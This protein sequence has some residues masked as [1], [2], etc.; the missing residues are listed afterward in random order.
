M[1]KG[2][3]K[4]KYNSKGLVVKSPIKIENGRKFYPGTIYTN[5][6][7]EKYVVLDYKDPFNVTIQFLDKHGYTYTTYRSSIVA[8]NVKNPYRLLS[9]GNYIGDGP[10]ARKKDAKAYACWKNINTRVF[11]SNTRLNASLEC[12]E[13]VQICEE[14]KNFQNFA[15]WYYDQLANLNSKY[16]YSIDKDI[17]Q[18][19]SNI[20]IYSPETAAMVPTNLNL[21]LSSYKNIVSKKG[22]PT[23]VVRKAN[24]YYANL[25]NSNSIDINI[26]LEYNHSGFNTPEEAFEE[27]RTAKISYIRK[28]AD[29]YYSENAISKTIRDALC[30]IDIIPF[31]DNQLRIQ[32]KSKELELQ[33]K[34][35]TQLE[36][37]V[38]YYKDENSKLKLVIYDHE[39]EIKKLQEQI[40]SSITIKR[41]D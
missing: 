8:G 40:R 39:A 27:Y 41:G 37:E 11:E 25:Y 19:N 18:W 1:P 29:F 23:G 16:K 15:Q 28:I 17:L 6:E 38:E 10:Y 33:R 24:L 22:L 31:S 30:D 32:D 20:K 4:L 35:I 2:D 36:K 21:G 3:P 14:W 5:N 9:M 12:Y 34:R 26:P 13:E 7:G